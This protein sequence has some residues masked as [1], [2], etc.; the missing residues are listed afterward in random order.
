MVYSF[1]FVKCLYS[2]IL[3]DNIK[4]TSGCANICLFEDKILVAFEMR[5]KANVM[6]AMCDILSNGGQ[7]ATSTSSRRKNA[8]VE[9]WI[10]CWFIAQKWKHVFLNPFWSTNYSFFLLGFPSWYYPCHPELMILWWT[11]ACEFQLC[12]SQSSWTIIL[13]RNICVLISYQL[14]WQTSCNAS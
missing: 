14:L 10:L 1:C 11:V 13:Q 12:N 8:W 6:S 5:L 3:L 4:W 9:R 2:L 7:E